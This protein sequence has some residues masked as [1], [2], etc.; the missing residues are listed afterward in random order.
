MRVPSHKAPPR[1]TRIAIADDHPVIRH[2]AI[3]V[4]SQLP[5]MHVAAS[6]A[7]G[8]E[9]LDALRTAESHLIITDLLML[10][11]EAD[12]DGLHLM[13]RLKRLYPGTPI[14]VFT[15]IRNF[16]I[17]HELDQMDVAG[18][19]SKSESVGIFIEAVRDV[20]LRRRQYRSPG[21]LAILNGPRAS[22]LALTERSSLSAKEFEVIR[23]YGAGLSL[24]EIAACMNRSVSTVATQKS[25]AMRKLGIATNA[26]MIRYV[27]AHRLIQ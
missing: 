13:R 17:L 2:A 25:N 7:S 12:R 23:L 21:V 8:A 14:I 5:D 19:V 9:L 3:A 11:V 1:E 26:D 20:A 15:M 6:V 27:Q 10:G 24:T 4:L 16:D 22:T 18:I